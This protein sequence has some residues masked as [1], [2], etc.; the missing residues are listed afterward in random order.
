MAFGLLPLLVR[1][2]NEA[3]QKTAPETERKTVITDGVW[4]SDGMNEIA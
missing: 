3:G 4:T 2:E 1:S